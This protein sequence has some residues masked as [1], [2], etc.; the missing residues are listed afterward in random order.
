L[1]R[2]WRSW[3]ESESKLE[4]RGSTTTTS[5]RFVKNVYYAL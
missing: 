1:R 4:R 5:D 2:W 3:Q